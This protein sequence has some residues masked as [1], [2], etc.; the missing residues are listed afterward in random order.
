MR[1]STVG[2]V[3]QIWRQSGINQ[4]GVSKHIA[5]E[6]A[7]EAGAEGWHDVGKRLGVHSYKTAD[8]YRDVWINVAKYVRETYQVKDLEKLQGEHIAGYL[9][10]KVDAG[11]A[12]STLMTYSAAVEKLE[13]ALNLYAEITH[14]ERS[15]NW[16]SELK[17]VRQEY[18][19]L[20]RNE[21]SRA[22]DNPR[23]LIGEIR[24]D[25]YN[26]IARTQYESG[27]RLD[28][29]RIETR[30]LHGM[31]PDPATG[32]TK[33]WIEVEGKGGKIREIGVQ[34]E[35]YKAIEQQVRSNGGSWG[36][37]DDKDR[38]DYREALKE[39]SMTSGEAY[40]GS[41]GLRWDYAQERFQELQ[42]HGGMTYNEALAE[43]SREMG[44]E[45]ADIT[46]HYLR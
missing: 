14:S 19:S 38:Q 22:H 33:G 15:Y 28:E 6:T 20:E 37:G 24:D 17:D 43:V 39:A 1:G 30:D 3:T 36:I 13:T 18:K 16:Q 41:H 45:R 40:T 7:R 26:L 8:L 31:R 5:K 4:I 27:A 42:T 12:H 46:E 35:T 44:H 25:R 9:Q 10:S 32:E 23:A 21:G 34:S 29:V 11:L 2:Q